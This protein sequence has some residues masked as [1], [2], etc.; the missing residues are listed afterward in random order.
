M[1]SHILIRFVLIGLVLGSTIAPLSWINRRRKLHSAVL[2]VTGA[3]AGALCGLVI[4]GPEFEYPF[5]SAFTIIV[6][7]VIASISTLASLRAS[8][9][10]F[11][12]VPKDSRSDQK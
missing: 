9:Q 12:L 2:L 1:P 7:A 11:D 8:D 6:G 3:I 5:A 10:M 4:T